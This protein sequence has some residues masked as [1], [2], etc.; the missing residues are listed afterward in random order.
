MSDT[1]TPTRS[2]AVKTLVV[3][4]LVIG[5][6]LALHFGIRALVALHTG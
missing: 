2:R 6:G 3:T 5:V 1:P 4:A